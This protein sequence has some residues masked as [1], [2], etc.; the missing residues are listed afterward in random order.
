MG[1][2]IDQHEIR[3]EVKRINKV[4]KIVLHTIAIGDFQ[5]NFMKALAKDNGGVY[6]D[7]GK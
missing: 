2:V 7:L 3:A 4:R 6:V 1:K 5:K